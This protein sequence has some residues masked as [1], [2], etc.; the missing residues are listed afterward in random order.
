M[1]KKNKIEKTFQGEKV[2]TKFRSQLVH[3]L[4]AMQRSNKRAY[5]GKVLTE[6]SHN[7]PYPG[8]STSIKEKK[9]VDQGLIATQPIKIFG[10]HWSTPW[11]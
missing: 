8:W 3:T 4:V 6:F 9:G 5:G 2:L 1:T 7:D 10:C 11:S